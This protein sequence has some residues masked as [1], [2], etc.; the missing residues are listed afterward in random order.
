MFQAYNV[1]ST[2]YAQN[3]PIIFPTVKFSDCRVRITNS[4]TITIGAPGRY[5]ISFNGTASSTQATSPFEV[6][7]Y[8]NGSA[9]EET[10]SVV[11][12]VAA[13]DEG[14]LS[15]TTIVNVMPS[16]NCAQ[17]SITLQVIATATNSGTVSNSNLVIYRLK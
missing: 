14:T 13:N 16:C 9:L 6:K 1:T 11:T 5:L 10:A 3:A 4:N 8:Q 7:L 12:S 17:N 15:F 2:I